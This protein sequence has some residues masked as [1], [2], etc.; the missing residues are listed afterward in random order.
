MAQYAAVFLGVNLVPAN[1][2]M[3]NFLNVQLLKQPEIQYQLHFRCIPPG[4]LKTKELKDNRSFKTAILFP[5]FLLIEY[6]GDPAA[7]SPQGRKVDKNQGRNRPHA[8]RSGAGAGVR[9]RIGAGAAAT[10][11]GG[12]GGGGG[13]RSGGGSRGRGGGGGWG[14]GR[15]RGQERGR[16]R[17]RERGRPPGPCAGTQ[18]TAARYRHCDLDREAAEGGAETRRK[19]N[20]EGDPGAGWR[21]TLSEAG[22]GVGG[23]GNCAPRVPTAAAWERSRALSEAV[24]LENL[25]RGS[26]GSRA[27]M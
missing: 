15:G 17:R 11:G 2:P 4:C 16:G 26:A 1:Y 18:S 19:R 21:S 23:D 22:F 14:R 12:G 20:R 27:D 5:F 8:P 6:S 7:P 9:E 13:G 3:A 24:G 25:E 10:G